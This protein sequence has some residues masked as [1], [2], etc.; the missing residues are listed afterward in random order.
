MTENTFYAVVYAWLVLGIL[1]FPLLLKIPAPYGRHTRPG[2]GMSVPN[3]LG[4]LIMELPALAIFVY[5]FLTGNNVQTAATWFFF[6][7]WAVHYSNRSFVFPF[8]LKTTQ[9]KMPVV[10]M[11]MAI[12]FNVVNGFICG[13]YFGSFAP[14]YGSAW[15]IDP[16]FLTGMISRYFY[17]MMVNTSSG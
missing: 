2:W 9:K 13:H 8:R 11:S 15:L 6:V 14:R 1:V 3:H 17:L 5:F 7:L 4:W 10:I 12:V 16:R